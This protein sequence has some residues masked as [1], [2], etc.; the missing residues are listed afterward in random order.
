MTNIRLQCYRFIRMH[1]DDTTSLLDIGCGC[2]EYMNRLPPANPC[3]TTTLENP[4]QDVTSLENETVLLINVIERLSSVDQLLSKLKE[5][6][7]LQVI[8]TTSVWPT[9]QALINKHFSDYE[10]EFAL[11]GDEMSESN[12]QGVV[13]SRVD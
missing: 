5:M 13:C 3:H 9:T 10:L 7:A 6:R 4:L 2:G 8:I 12:I 11:V 1:V